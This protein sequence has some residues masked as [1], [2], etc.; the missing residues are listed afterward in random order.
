MKV[1]QQRHMSGRY[2]FINGMSDFFA[3]LDNSVWILEDYFLDFCS[4]HSVTAVYRMHLI[5]DIFT[6]ILLSLDNQ[7][8]NRLS[9]DV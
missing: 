3:E 4:I 5:V 7:Q 1:K 2:A 9:S 6:T 8:N